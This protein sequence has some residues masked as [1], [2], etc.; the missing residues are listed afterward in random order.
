MGPAACC[1][2]YAYNKEDYA[3]RVDALKNAGAIAVIFAEGLRGKL[4]HQMRPVETKPVCVLEARQFERLRMEAAWTQSSVTRKLL[5]IY[6]C[7]YLREMLAW[8]V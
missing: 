7:E 4:A 1:R 6:P 3:A 8:T 2:H 5:R